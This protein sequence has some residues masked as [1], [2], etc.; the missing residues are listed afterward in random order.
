ME[1][2]VS[3]TYF[4][5]NFLLRIDTLLTRRSYPFVSLFVGKREITEKTFE[6]DSY[7][8]PRLLVW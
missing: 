6:F 5:L 2:Y 8:T 1:W 7:T 3:C 4:F